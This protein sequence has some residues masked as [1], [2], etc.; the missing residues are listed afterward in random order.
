MDSNTV[1]RFGLNSYFYNFSI[2]DFLRTIKSTIWHQEAPPGGLA[3]CA[4]GG[5]VALAKKAGVSV[6]QDGTGLDEAFGGY[7]NH[8]NMY[9]AIKIKQNASDW[10]SAVSNYSKS[11]GVTESQAIDSAVNSVGGSVT[12]I[13]GTLSTR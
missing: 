11:W 3:N 2:N 13:D 4:L 12:A 8:H 5:L 1:E 7:R 9:L 6:L 10:R